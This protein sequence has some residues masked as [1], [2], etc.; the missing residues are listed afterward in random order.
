[1]NPNRLLQNTRSGWSP[2]VIIAV[3]TLATIAISVYCLSSDY[4]IIFQNLFYIP[5]I[6][7]CVYYTKRGFAF[8][9]IIACIYYFLTLVFTRDSSILLQAFIRVLIFVLVAGIITYLSSARKRVE[10]VLRESRERFRQLIEMLP[11]AVCE[12]DTLGKV[13]FANNVASIMVGYDQADIAKGVNIFSMIAPED[14]ERAANNIRRMMEGE[15]LGSDEY[16]LV[17]KNGSK[18]PAFVHITNILDRRGKTIGFRGIVVD[19]TERKQLEEA[20]QHL[21]AIVESSHD[22]IIGKTLDGIITSWNKGAEERYGYSAAE[23]IGRSIS[24]IVPPDR[25]DEVS[26]FLEKIRRGQAVIDYEA[27]RIT[28]DGRRVSALVTLSPIKD[29]S[30]KVVGAS[31]IAQDITER[32]RAEEALRRSEV[33]YKTIFESS[34]DAIMLLTPEKG[35]FGGNLACLEMFRCKDEEEFSS[36]SPADM[37]PE[38]Q[39]DGSLSTVKAQK[40]MAIAMEKGSSYFEWIHKR[41][42]GE[43]FFA[44][45]LL[46][47]MDL[48]NRAVLQATVRDITE[49]KQLQQKLEEMA[50]HDVLTGLPNRVLL[51]DRFTIAAALA[52]RNKARLAV[53]SLDLDKFKS[54][55]DTLGHDAG[56]QVLKVISARL[57]GTIRASDTLARVGGDEF[58]LVMTETGGMKDTAVLAQKV[59]DAFK[60]PLIVD[61]HQLHLSTSIGIAIYPEDADDLETLTKKSDAAMY[62]AKGHGRNQFKCWGDGDV[63]IGSDHKSATI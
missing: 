13:V 3:T 21:A 50:T 1:M 12:I 19:I 11:E 41:I 52:H 20:Q 63:R 7:A 26:R 24:I 44:T 59:L 40:M 57:T 25:A 55:N 38:Y 27:E 42:D 60:E 47:R 2:F 29:A 43:E 15:A 53:M 33:K 28:K 37:S 17:R 31:T 4:F 18:F 62:Y 61:G 58:I 16:T 48:G 56:D 22:A 32:K 49:R 46:T 5:I 14:Q 45:V 9:V 36:K 10:E 39:P 6:I 35:F 51:L 8:S 54:I 23:V 34:K 30:G